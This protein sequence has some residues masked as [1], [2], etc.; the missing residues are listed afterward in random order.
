MRFIRS[1]RDSD[2]P[3]MCP[4]GC[5]RGVLTYALCTV[6]LHRFVDDFERHIRDEDLGLRD[7]DESGFGVASVNGGGCVKDD[8]SCGIDVDACFCYPV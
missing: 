7:F 2:C 3:D 6:G 1:I 5:E 8:K 4:H